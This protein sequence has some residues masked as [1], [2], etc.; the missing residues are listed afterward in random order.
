M[1]DFYLW[2]KAI[3]IISVICW[4]AGLLYLPRLFVYHVSLYGNDQ[5]VEIFK[6]ME[7]RLLN[8][9]MNPS[10]L[11]SLL[12]GSML[13][14]YFDNVDWE[15]LWIYVKI[16]FIMGLIVFHLFMISWQRSFSRDK[17]RYSE[18]FYRIVNEVPAVFM[19]VIVF[20]VILRPF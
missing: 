11:L 9:I 4:M 18:K 19:I 20:M 15:S 13:L 8:G 5:A 12:T 1:T 7:R 17:N 6:M 3:H 2:T 16:I 14:F 10:L